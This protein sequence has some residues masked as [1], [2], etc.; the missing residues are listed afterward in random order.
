MFLWNTWIFTFLHSRQYNFDPNPDILSLFS[1]FED[2]A[3]DEVSLNSQLLLRNVCS[4]LL[5]EQNFQLS[6]TLR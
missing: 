1:N 5:L 6:L 4:S 2:F 3:S